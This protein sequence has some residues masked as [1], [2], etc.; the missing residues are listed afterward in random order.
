MD[1]IARTT[2]PFTLHTR[3][4]VP[5]LQDI[6]EPLAATN[7]STHS[8]GQPHHFLDTASTRGERIGED[9]QDGF[10]QKSFHCRA[11]LARLFRWRADL[12]PLSLEG[13]GCGTAKSVVGHADQ[14]WLGAAAA[15]TNLPKLSI[16]PH[17]HYFVIAL[18]ICEPRFCY[19]CSFEG[20]AASFSPT[21]PTS[22]LPPRSQTGLRL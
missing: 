15:P 18:P 5:Q 17:G 10:T 3:I 19:S 21:W 1:R 11:I 6:T 7:G 2:S 16:L 4:S 9:E 12:A 14:G 20:L 13:S 22:R 8:F